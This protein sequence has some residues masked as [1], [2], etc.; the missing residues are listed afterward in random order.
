M[1]ESRVNRENYISIQG[2]MVRD[3]R[4]K[5]NE[6]MVYAIIYGFSQAENQVF[7]G[8]LQYLAD[9]T[10]STKQS[11]LN[12]LKSLIEKEYIVKNE[13]MIN[14]VKFCEYYVTELTTV[15]K[16]VE[17]PIKQSLTGGIEESLPNNISSNTL[18]DN[19][20]KII[21]YLNAKL[22]SKYSYKTKKT[23]DCIKARFNE[24]EGLTVE[25][26]Y[27]VI[28]KQYDKWNGTD[29]EQ[30]LRPETLFGNKFEGYLNSKAKA[31]K[32]A[33]EPKRYGGTYL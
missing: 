24:I 2:F 26:F 1:A 18:L 33:Q 16:K 21:D 23:Q 22:N 5:G 11:V 27:I 20:K 31:K 13:K 7:N 25:D 3:L 10:N 17:Y 8:S 29:M 32:E 30:Y 6:L 12:C 28:D 19:I 15:L 4:L 14:G 9:W